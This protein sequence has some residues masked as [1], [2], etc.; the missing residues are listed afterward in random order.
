MKSVIKDNHIT[1]KGT[2]C[3]DATING[4]INSTTANINT[5]RINILT[6]T[7]S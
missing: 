4:A 1:T 6:N 7:K 3:K 5:V 2:Q